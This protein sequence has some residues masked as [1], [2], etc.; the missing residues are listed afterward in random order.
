[1]WHI[2]GERFLQGIGG[3]AS[4]KEQLG[5]L[6]HR[7]DDIIKMCFQETEWE[8][9]DWIDLAQDGYMTGS[10]EHGYDPSHFIKCRE[11]F[12]QLKNC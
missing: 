6:E 8:G 1:M 2:G 3:E 9:V 4:W 5:W 12:D 7:W 10:C 11:F